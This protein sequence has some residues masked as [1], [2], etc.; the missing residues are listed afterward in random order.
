MYRNL[1]IILSK[2]LKIGSLLYLVL[3]YFLNPVSFNLFYSSIQLQESS[4]IHGDKIRKK[5]NAL[6]DRRDSINF[7]LNKI[8][9]P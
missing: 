5:A 8:R 2:F 4:R 9:C 1:I 6:S 3:K 7:M